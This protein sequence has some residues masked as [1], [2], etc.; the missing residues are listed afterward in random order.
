MLPLVI[1]VFPMLRIG[2]ELWVM[3][4]IP[5]VTPNHKGKTEEYGHHQNSYLMF[6]S[7]FIIIIAVCCV[8]IQLHF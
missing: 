5:T 3:L 6:C 2:K 7:G 8:T 1:T 4:Q